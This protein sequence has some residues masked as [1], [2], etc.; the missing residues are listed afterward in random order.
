ML[1][2][3][4]CLPL[5]TPSSKPQWQSSI[6]AFRKDI[7]AQGLNPE[8]IPS[9]DMLHLTLGVMSLTTEEK[10]TAACEL[11]KGD[12]VRKLIWRR[13]AGVNCE[14]EEGE[15]NSTQQERLGLD[16]S[17]RQ[18]KTRRNSSHNAPARNPA[19]TSPKTHQRPQQ[20]D[21][22]HGDELSP[23]TPLSAI[24][25]YQISLS[26]LHTTRTRTSTSVLYASLSPLVSPLHILC[27]SLHELFLHANLLIP[28]SRPLLLH[29]TV[30][31]TLYYAKKPEKGKRFDAKVLMEKWEQVGWVSD[32]KIER[33]AIWEMGAKVDAQKG[34]RT[35][36]E[37][38]GVDLS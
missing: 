30:F 24:S 2:H 19:G 38:E 3:F 8:A 1:T 7:S 29:A 26:G 15:G 4:L 20:A 14:G 33:V 22:V 32:L 34:G 12:E 18:E 5:C 13:I 17:K 31:N 35:Y 6:Q 21:S 10:K 25:P 28:D 27:Q 36:T 9:V 16:K 11:L 23:P 37:L